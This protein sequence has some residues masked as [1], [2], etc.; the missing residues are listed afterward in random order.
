[1]LTDTMLTDTLPTLHKLIRKGKKAIRDVAD[2]IGEKGQQKRVKNVRKSHENCS[3]PCRVI[4]GKKG[5]A[6]CL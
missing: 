3:K 4:V 5:D 6:L 1:M 2:T